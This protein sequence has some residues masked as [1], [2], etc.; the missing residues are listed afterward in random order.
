MGTP[1]DQKTNELE[2][3][4]PPLASAEF[5]DNPSGSYASYQYGQIVHNRGRQVGQRLHFMS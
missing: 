3:T 1:V 5:G 4:S 2:L